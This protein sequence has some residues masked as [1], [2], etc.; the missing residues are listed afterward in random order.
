M[1]CVLSIK[2]KDSNYFVTVAH[3]GKILRY[4]WDEQ[5][6][7]LTWTTFEQLG[8]SLVEDAGGVIGEANC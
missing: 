8:A 7:K 5:T 2:H 4:E 1:V 3:S 6:K